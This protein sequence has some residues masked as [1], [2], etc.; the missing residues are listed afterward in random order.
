MQ[1]HRKGGRIADLGGNGGVEDMGI[2]LHVLVDPRGVPRLEIRKKDEPV[3]V[4]I[5]EGQ[6][7]ARRSRL[8]QHALGQGIAALRRCSALGRGHRV[9]GG[10]FLLDR[11]NEQAGAVGQS[12]RGIGVVLDLDAL[13][14]LP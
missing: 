11:A 12:L 4:L 3:L 8:F 5:L 1:L 9:I 13:G 10:G 7:G 2:T 6:G 14:P